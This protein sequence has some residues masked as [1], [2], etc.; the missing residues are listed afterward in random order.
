VVYFDPYG[1]VRLSQARFC[2][3][4]DWILSIDSISPGDLLL[5]NGASLGTANPAELPLQ[6]PSSRALLVRFVDFD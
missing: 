2:P 3:G 5:A 4:I 6:C 1:G